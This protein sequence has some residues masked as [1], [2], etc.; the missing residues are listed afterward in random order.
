MERTLRHWRAVLAIYVQ[1]GLAYRASALIWVLTDV[2]TAVTMPLVMAAAA[3]GGA[4][5]GYDG[6]AFILYYLTMLMVTS[7]VT[8]H[9]MWEIA[10]EIKEGV[11]SVY[12]VR[13]I[14]FFQ[15]MAMRNLAWRVVRTIIFM[16]LF[17]SLVLLYANHLGGA[18]LHLGPVFWLSVVLGH[19]VSFTF[20]MAIAMIALFIQEAQAVFEL[21]YVPMLFLSGQ[22][23]PVALLPDWARALALAFPFYYTTGLPT[24]IAVGRLA[25]GGEW[26]LIGGQVAWIVGSYLAYRVLWRLGLRHYSGVGM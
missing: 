19:L 22:L 15:F 8:S 21:Y 23:F 2:T 5:Q 25:A 20:V 26:P 16:P 12:L 3:A 4:I 13:P 18:S 7:F 24:E 10:N 17:A 1:D 6:Q 14:S 11:F 9:F